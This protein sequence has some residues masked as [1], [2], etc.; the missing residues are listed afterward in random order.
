VGVT[1]RNNTWNPPE[2]LN[3]NHNHF[4][5]QYI[6][7][8]GIPHETVIVGS[9]LYIQFLYDEIQRLNIQAPECLDPNQAN[10]PILR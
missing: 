5:A 1:E 9:L 2:V 4:A 7:P 10:T 8:P 3:P 6:Y